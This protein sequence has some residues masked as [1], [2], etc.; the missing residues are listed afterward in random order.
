MSEALYYPYTTVQSIDNLMAMV[1]YFDTIYIINPEKAAIGDRLIR[2]EISVLEREKIIRYI[3]PAELLEEYDNLM[4]QSVINDLG[5]SD[6]LNL[7]HNK[8]LPKVWKIYT[9]KIPNALADST[10]R[11]YLVN[12]PALYESQRFGHSLREGPFSHIEERHQAYERMREISEERSN[13]YREY[14]FVELPFEYG[15]SLMINHALCAC[16]KFSLTPLTDHQVHHDF[17]KFKFAQMQNTVLLKRILKDYGFIKDM[18]IDLAAIDIISETVPILEKASVTDVLEFRDENK[19]ALERFRIE[20]GRVAT[21]IEGNFW[22]EDFSQKI[23]DTI[24]DKVKPAIQNVKDSTESIKEKF[25][26]IL[27][28]GAKISPLPIF[29]SVAVGCPPE[30]A[31]AAG[32]GVLSLDEYLERLRGRRVKRRNGFA[33]L[34]EAQKRFVI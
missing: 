11:K 34:F 29:A 13:R 32:A 20:M 23:I 7:C 22:D 12:V 26:R 9:E 24:D 28:K 30:I 27:A 6:F 25:L 18:K 15:E 1:L 5:N 33:Y 4:T 2:Q 21:K 17:L 16:D 31:L 8:A 14:R 19:D 10:F 3:S